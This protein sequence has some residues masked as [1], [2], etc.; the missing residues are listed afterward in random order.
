MI[1]VETYQRSYDHVCTFADYS[2]YDPTRTLSLR[3]AFAR[4][5]RRRFRG[6]SSLIRKSVD[7]EDVFGLKKPSVYQTPGNRAFAFLTT[8]EQIEAFMSWIREEIKKGILEIIEMEQLGR[9][10]MGAWTDL[11]VLDA[12]KR[13]IARARTEMRAA[14]YDVPSLEETGGI[15]ASMST[16]F[17][18][19]RVGILFTRV[20]TDL[21]G[22]TEAMASQIARVLAEGMIQGDGARLI[23]RKLVATIEG[24]GMGKLGITDTLG[25]FIPAMRRAE[26]IARTELIRAYHLAN[27]QEMR[28]W[29]VVGVKV[30]AEFSTAGDDRVCDICARLEGKIYTLDE[31]EP[32]IPVH[33]MCRCVALPVLERDVKTIK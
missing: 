14:G 23:A 20:F 3:N 11:Y 32:M 22:V 9:P 28:N 17:H 12:Y 29:G 21:V 16:P 25:R 30:R 2:R 6:I 8:E 10:L 33:P 24:V 4:A 19:D 18:M 15:T 31:I 7:E 27:V 1:E 13:G 26:M 5:M